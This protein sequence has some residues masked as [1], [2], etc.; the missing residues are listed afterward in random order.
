MTRTTCTLSARRRTLARVAALLAMAACAPLQAAEPARDIVA[1]QIGPF[2]ARASADVAE[3][4]EG[5]RA[6][7]EEANAQGGVRGRPIRLVTL[8]DRRD[9]DVFVKRFHEAMQL[10]PVA[11]L[12][13][14][15]ST[16]VK[17]LLDERLLDGADIVV[18]NAIPGAEVLRTPGHAKLFHVRAG[19]RL[20]IEHI[21]RHAATLG[22]QRIVVWH[23]DTPAGKS[24][25]AIVRSVAAR[26]DGG[27]QALEVVAVESAAEAAAL[28]ADAARVGQAG[29]Q[30]ALVLG[31]PTFMAE[32]VKHLRANGH[33]GPIYAP[34]D[35][36]PQVLVKAAGEKA[37]RGVGIARNVPDPQGIAQPVQRAFAAA[38]RA[39][40]PSIAR[41]SALHFEG[42]LTA[43]I[44]AQALRRALDARPAALAAALRAEAMDFGGFRVDFRGGQVG[45]RFVDIGVVTSDGH[46]AY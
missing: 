10:Q 9:A 16:L 17:R 46:I 24:G 39:A 33:G 4:N 14:M 21:V 41:Y 30:S 7:L 36:S 18:L 5:L 28:Q 27:S 1:V 29:A 42:Y 45:S 11:L 22:I 44:F 34:S 19:D 23:Q 12:S 25:A 32:A 40:H 37:A 3:L 43:R 2:G 8:D 15:G 6:G 26:A 20:Q 13:P 35:L 31:S 38:M